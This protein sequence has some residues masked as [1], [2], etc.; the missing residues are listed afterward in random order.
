MVAGYMLGSS[1]RECAATA[2]HW[3]VFQKYRPAPYSS[4]PA[5]YAEPPLSFDL[6]YGKPVEVH[7][8]FVSFSGAKVG[9]DPNATFTGRVVA[10]L[11]GGTWNS[12]RQHMDKR[13]W[14]LVEHAEHFYFCPLD[15]D[16]L[17][18]GSSENLPERCADME[19]CKRYLKELVAERAPSGVNSSYQWAKK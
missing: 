15:N 12:S 9:V 8:P 6:H 16:R 14:V 17:K 10:P 19:R 1:E 2:N 7:P 5:R 3:E 11:L 4:V 18:E 13:R